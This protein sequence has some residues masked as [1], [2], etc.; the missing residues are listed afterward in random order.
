VPE[1]V[2]RDLRPVLDEEIDRLPS[3]FREAFVLCHLQERTNEQAARELGCPV[4][5][6]L[7][8]LARARQRLRV[9]LTRRGITLPAGTLAAILVGR[10]RASPVPSACLELTLRATLGVATGKPAAAATVSVHAVL[11][12]EGVLKAM[13][14]HRLRLTA[15]ILLLAGLLGTVAYSRQDSDPGTRKE[16]AATQDKKGSS[17]RARDPGVKV[18]HSEEEEAVQKAGNFGG[19][20]GHAYSDP[21]KE[22]MRVANKLLQEEIEDEKAVLE[23]LQKK[24]ERLKKSGISLPR[25]DEETAQLKRENRHLN[26]ELRRLQEEVRL[27]QEDVQPY[28]QALQ[29]RAGGHYYREA[30]TGFP[31]YPEKK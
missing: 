20:G 1:V 22:A 28:M 15:G 13:F 27:A 12:A 25:E 19:R 16:R 26:A 7:S 10:L 23:A 14:F 11:L 29:E 24:M 31:S 30:K 3:P 8:R 5:T 6:L 4:G 18:V 17:F 9:R 2:W 21:Q